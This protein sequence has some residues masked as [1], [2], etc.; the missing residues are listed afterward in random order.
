M[1]QINQKINIAIIAG[2]LVVGGAER[3]LYLWLANLDRERYNPIVLTLHP[4]HN[5]Y[6]EKPVESLG[7]PLI[8]IPQRRNRIKRLQEIVKVLRPYNL[9]LIHGWHL[10]AGVYAGLA[11]K[12]LRTKSIGGIR[13]T[14]QTF[15]NHR[16]EVKLTVL[17]V[18]ALVANSIST[19]EHLMKNIRNEKL[20]VFAVQNAVADH[21]IDRETTR[22]RLIEDYNL[23]E[24]SLW[25]G[26]I[27]RMEPLK[28]FDILLQVIA[29]LRDEGRNVHL[30]LIGD[31]PEEAGLEKQ[32]QELF[33]NDHVTFTG[34]LGGASDCLRA[35]DLFAFTSIDEGMPNVIMEAAAAGLPIVTWKLPF[36]E[37]LLQDGK[38]ALLVEAE[39]IADMKNALLQLIDSPELRTRLGQAA[40]EHILTNF[41]LDRYVQNMTDVYESVLAAPTKTGKKTV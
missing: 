32:S 28:R 11:A 29:L 24:A 38:T 25:I 35:F 36:Y 23:P 26:S 33:L 6:W 16:L 31:G 39:N 40:R 18:N 37:E 7:I 34:E 5:D 41:S 27:G 21:F 14:Y 2:Q 20:K 1:N 15:S 13:N 9:R 3:Q 4:G 17:T 12:V 10:F 22:N 30:V 19:K 8:R